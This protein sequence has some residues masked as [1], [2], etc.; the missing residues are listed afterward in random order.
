MKYLTPIYLT[1]MHAFNNRADD[2][3]EDKNNKGLHPIS[4]LQEYCTLRID[5]G[6][7]SGK[8]EAVSRFAA[9]WLA[10]GKSVIVLANKSPYARKTRDRIMRRWM[11]LENIDKVKG[12]LVDDTIRNFLSDNKD[13]YRGLSLQRTLII[14]EEPIRIP[15][16]YKFYEAW[17]SMRVN[18]T[19]QGEVP[20]PLFFV[21]GIQ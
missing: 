15:E 14:I 9:E 6:R 7:Q 18:Y 5:G 19:S 10:D 20:L 8:T 17:E 13:R 16:M 3:L 4:L 1:L 21:M 11:A 2:C 12:V